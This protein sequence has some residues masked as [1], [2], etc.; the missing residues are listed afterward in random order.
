MFTKFYTIGLN[1]FNQLLNKNSLYI[2]GETAPQFGWNQQCNGTIFSVVFFILTLFVGL[3]NFNFISPAYA[4]ISAIQESVL[5]VI[6]I[7]DI[8]V[9]GQG[10][11]TIAREGK[12][13]T[14]IFSSSSAPASDLNINVDVEITGNFLDLNPRGASK[15]SRFYDGTNATENVIIATGSTRGHLRVATLDDSTDE[16]DG[17][18]TMTI[19][20]G[21]GY[22][23][24]ESKPNVRSAIVTDNDEPIVEVGIVATDAVEC[25]LAYFTLQGTPSSWFTTPTSSVIRDVWVNFEITRGLEFL[26]IPSSD[27]LANYET[28]IQDDWWTDDPGFDVTTDY[29]GREIKLDLASGIGSINYTSA[30]SLRDFILASTIADSV[31]ETIEI[32]LLPGAGYR[33]SPNL[34]VANQV[35]S[36]HSSLRQPPVECASTPTPPVEAN[37]PVISLNDIKVA[38]QSE[39]T[40]AREGK[41]FTFVFQASPPPTSELVVNV[42]VH[43]IGDF[44][45]VNPRGAS[46]G[47]RFYNGTHTT[48]NVI[49]NAGSTI[50]SLR[51]ATLDDLIDEADGEIKMTILNGTG[52][53]ITNTAQYTRSAVVTDNDEAKIEVEVSAAGATECQ[54]AHI[55]L[56]GTP[57]SWFSSPSEG[58]LKEVRVNFAITKGKEFLA[59]PSQEQLAAYEAWTRENS[60]TDDPSFDYTTDYLGNEVNL[61]LSSG[62][63]SIKFSSLITPR[64]FILASTI[65]GSVGET[66]EVTLLPGVGYTISP[67]YRVTS[68]Q[69]NEYTTSGQPLLG[70]TSISPPEAINPVIAITDVLVAGQRGRT[71]AREGKWFTFEFEASA[72]PNRDLIVNVNVDIDGNFLNPNPRGAALGTRF[73]DG[74]NATENVFIAAGSTFGYLRVATHDDAIDEAD[75]SI[76]MTLQDGSGYQITDSDQNSRSVTITDNDENERFSELFSEMNEVIL[77]TTLRAQGA[78]IQTALSARMLANPIEANKVT[79]TLNGQ[80]MLQDL[81]QSS[82]EYT[83]QGNFSWSSIL[84]DSTFSL[85]LFPNDSGNN[86]ISIWGLGNFDALSASNGNQTQWNGDFSTGHFGIDARFTSETVA[87]ISGSIARGDFDYSTVNSEVE[88]DYQMKMSLLNPYFGWESSDQKF[89]LQVTGSYGTGDIIINHDSLDPELTT[90]NLYMTSISGRKS[91]LTVDHFTENG[92]SEV[93]LIGDVFFA[94]QHVNENDSLISDVDI[95]VNQLRVSVVGSQYYNFVSGSQLNPFFA[96]GMR[97]DGGDGENWFGGEVS[98]KLAYTNQNGLSLMG[99]GETTIDWNNRQG[100]WGL[101]ASLEYDTSDDGHGLLFSGSSSIGKVGSVNTESFLIQE[102]AGLSVGNVD[103]SVPQWTTEVGYGFDILDSFGSYTPFSNLE[104]NQINGLKL[105]IGSRVRIGS[106]LSFVI[107]GSQ[108][109]LANQ[110]VGRKFDIQAKMNW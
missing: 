68:Q 24:S 81:I 9:A 84:N 89:T 56:N 58:E 53:S 54:F 42:D 96:V 76:T 107:E 95:N 69:I 2:Q 31:G 28:W 6:H 41:W 108:N 64:G 97:Q 12:W 35:I 77:P 39:R 10:E 79:F 38:G 90:S 75:G 72:A 50:S 30:K 32:T 47:S 34:N 29:F 3:L 100:E 18:I 37:D 110:A 60:W 7:D 106:L 11:R 15:G 85:N 109:Q 87:G 61:N 57:N 51:V 17:D 5:P 80:T 99:E 62:I 52:Y 105:G 101:R 82:G 22:R 83:N 74:T 26:S 65:E 27:Y 91:L 98:G 44:L 20:S 73:Y 49:F 14:F 33:I 40:I 25:Q 45:N 71:F 21:E 55:N 4:Q 102:V 70:C 88:S 36:Q 66:I 86:S 13:F 46:L 67:Q 16:E 48:S 104:F 78:S 93:D 59:I 103:Q 1:T 43:I 92:E 94:H 63:G 8:R 19:L 23:I